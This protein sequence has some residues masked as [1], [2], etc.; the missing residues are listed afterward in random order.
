MFHKD[1]LRSLLPLGTSEALRFPLSRSGV[2]NNPFLRH[3]SVCRE[4][5]TEVQ[6]KFHRKTSQRC[7][8]YKATKA[9]DSDS[10]AV[11]SR[12]S[13]AFQ[14]PFHDHRPVMTS[15]ASLAERPQQRNVSITNHTN[16]LFSSSRFRIQRQEIQLMLDAPVSAS[17]TKLETSCSYNL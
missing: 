4:K 11:T 16:T 1:L 5:R 14:R 7:V 12:S 8:G 13:I 6:R 2:A 9:V 17:D 3:C 10:C 15:E